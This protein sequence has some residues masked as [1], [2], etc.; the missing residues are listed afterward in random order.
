MR[1]SWLGCG[2]SLC[3]IAALANTT[4]SA[5]QD[6]TGNNSSSTSDQI[7]EIVV[8]GDRAIL[9]ALRGILPERT[10]DGSEIESHASSTVGEFLDEVQSQNGDD[11]PVFLVNGELITDIEDIADFPAEAIRQLELLPR[12]T[13]QLVGGPANRR[14]YNLVLKNKVRTATL[15]AGRR[16]ATEG[17]WGESKGELILTSIAGRDRLNLTFRARGSNSLY[18]SDRD[19]IQPAPAYPFDR[20]G[21]I[22]PFPVGGQEIDP[23]LSAM[24]GQRVSVAAV[25]SS[26]NRSLTLGDFSALA[27]QTNVTDIGRFRTLRP[28]SENY[29]LNLAGSNRILPWLSANYSLRA[30]WSSG[31]SQLG[32][33]G[34]LFQLPANNPASPFSQDVTLARYAERPLEQVSKNDSYNTNL[35]LTANSGPWTFGLTGQFDYADRTYETDRLNQISVGQTTLI[36]DSANPFTPEV[37]RLFDFAIDHVESRTVS[38]SLKTTANG[39]LFATPAGDL[40]IRIGLGAQSASVRSMNEFAGSIQ[41]KHFSRSDTNIEGGLDIPIA[42]R[43]AGFLPMLGELNVSLDH[44]RTNVSRIGIVTRSAAGI[45]WQPVGLINL[46]ASIERL[47]IPPSIETLTDPVVITE[48][49]RIFD[50]LTGE[51]VD[52]TYLFGGN[53]D[54]LSPTKETTQIT[55]NFAPMPRINL[56]LYASYSSVQTDDIIAALPPAGTDVFTAFPDRFQRDQLNNLILV[57]SRAVNFDRQKTEELRYSVSFSIPVGRAAATPASKASPID[58]AGGDSFAPLAPGSRPRL[59]FTASH[60][61]ALNDTVFTRPGLAP[62]NLLDGGAI[63]FGGGRPR[64]LV[65]GSIALSDRGMGVRLAGQWRSAS[66]VHIRDAQSENELRFAPFGTLNLRAFADLSNAFPQSKWLKATRVTVAFNN[67]TNHRQTVTDNAEATPLRYQPGYRDAVGQT[68]EIES[69]KIF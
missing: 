32:L 33:P 8:T 35:R 39:P 19:I 24:A 16:I 21:N 31:A 59:Q 61:V 22:I 43:R 46:S 50:F 23:A 49:V 48:N 14:V 1:Y 51:T 44:S 12:G 68:V 4:Q 38:R 7:S 52:V 60:G 18:E 27:G 5:A 9:A 30:R 25:L 15:S 65:D 41:A 47:K 11:E 66:T 36:P 54:L 62:V 40:R 6:T 28:D 37:D 17:E 2:S 53:P 69:R 34:L 63:G 64:H 56:Q 20:L 55:A 3:A 67:L 10:Y 13:S 58:E 29:D 45:L 57:D 42:S 26:F